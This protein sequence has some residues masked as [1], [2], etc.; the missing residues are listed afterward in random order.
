MLASTPYKP[1]RAS[2]FDTQKGYADTPTTRNAQ[3]LLF[4]F[5]SLGAIEAGNVALSVERLSKSG[6]NFGA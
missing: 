4:L 3:S 5:H 2:P 6:V 1:S